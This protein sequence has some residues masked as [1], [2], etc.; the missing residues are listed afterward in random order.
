MSN[1]MKKG[2]RDSVNK[3]NKLRI[4][5]VYKILEELDR[6]A[7]E[8]IRYS[9]E[10]KKAIDRKEIRELAAQFTDM[11]IDDLE[12]S[13]IWAK[14]NNFQDKLDEYRKRGTQEEGNNIS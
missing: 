7:I 1:F 10:N 3:T 2:K 14:M 13:V 11:K 5:E 12:E 8:I 4:E 6:V 9:S